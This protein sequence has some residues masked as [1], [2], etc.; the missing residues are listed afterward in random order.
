VSGGFTP[1]VTLQLAELERPAMLSRID[2]VGASPSVDDDPI[3]LAH[4]D[5][6]ARSSLIMICY[7]VYMAVG[8]SIDTEESDPRRPSRAL[9]SFSCPNELVDFR[10]E[11]IGVRYS[12][13]FPLVLREANE[14]RLHCD[15]VAPKGAR[16]AGD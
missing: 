11:R 9:S 7:G 16:H 15:A 12:S 14:I 10:I 4:A 2:R 5:Q 1:N 3:V 6:K 13:A 8:C